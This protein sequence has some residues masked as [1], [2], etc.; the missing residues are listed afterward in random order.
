MEKYKVD[1]DAWVVL[2]NH[3][4]LLI[5]VVEGGLVGPFVRELHGATAHF[6]K[7]NL[8][9]LITEFGQRLTR[10]VTPWDKRQVKRLSAEE[11]RLKREL[12][13]A[14]TNE[15]DILAQFIAR[16]QKRFKPEVYRGLKSAITNG[17]LTDPAI[18][19]SLIAKDSP[20]WY[21]YLDRVIRDERDYYRHLNYIHQN[22]VKH[23][24]TTKIDDYGFSSIHQF[25]KEKGKGWVIGCFE[26][27]PV[28]DFEPEGIA[29]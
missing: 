14:T 15:A 8:P 25:I 9:P 17:R 2:D 16:Y 22:P 18:V 10:E 1:L 24:Y 28:V 7:K 3:Y 29:D 6:I 23:G 19:V 26:S 27:Y 5:R 12:K 4:H 21:Q 11:Q 13:F 20:I